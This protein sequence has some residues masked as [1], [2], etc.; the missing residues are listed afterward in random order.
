M[1]GSSAVAAAA[2]SI[3]VLALLLTGFYFWRRRRRGL[4]E[5]QTIEKLQS[6]ENSQQRSGSGTLKLHYQSESEGKRR[7]SNFHP[8]GV[9][10]SLCS[11]GT[12]A[13]RSLT[14]PSKMDGPNLLLP[15]TCHLLQLQDPVC[16]VYVRPERSRRRYPRRRLAGK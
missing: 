15:V 6:V 12:T 4:I 8:R 7:L 11:V 1:A 13:H 2:V 14:T 16:W 9:S 10:Q 5:S 3:A